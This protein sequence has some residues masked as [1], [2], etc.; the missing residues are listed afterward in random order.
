MADAEINST[1]RRNIALI[2]HIQ[3]GKST[4]N[5]LLAIPRHDSPRAENST[6]TVRIG[7]ST[8]DNPFNES[9]LNQ[10]TLIDTPGHPELFGEV[11][12]ALRLADGAVLIVDCLEGV[13]PPAEWAVRHSVLLG[14]RPVLFI[15]KLDKAVLETSWTPK[16]VSMNAHKK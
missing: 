14:L 7:I 12:S 9:A 2:G 6:Q 13:R 10:F 11:K 8:V 4:T 16:Q 5:K 15:N 3:H 1:N